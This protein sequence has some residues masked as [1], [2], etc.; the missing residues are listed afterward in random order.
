MTTGSETVI[1]AATFV[2]LALLTSIVA[3][4]NAS[5]DSHMASAFQVD[6]CSGQASPSV[7]IQTE[8]DLNQAI[9]CFNSG[10]LGP[11]V[12]QLKLTRDVYVRTERGGTDSLAIPIDQPNLGYA[13][14]IN[15][16]RKFIDAP[17]LPGPTALSLFTMTE[18]NLA[19]VIFHNAMF[20]LPSADANLES[21][22][23]NQSQAPL[24]VT[25]TTFFDELAVLDQ[26]VKIENGGLLTVSDS[27][28]MLGDLGI[29]ST[30]SPVLINSSSFVRTA[31]SGSFGYALLVE[32][33]GTLE[34]LN[35][36]FDMADIGAIGVTGSIRNSTISGTGL[37]GNP[38]MTIS[39]SIINTCEAAV[40]DGGNNVGG[41]F[42][43]EIE[44]GRSSDNG[45]PGTDAVRCPWTI[46]IDA[47]SPARSAGDCRGIPTDQRGV[48]RTP[49]GISCD[50][51]AF[52]F[53]PA[54]AGDADNS[55]AVDNADVQALLTTL[56]GGSPPPGIEAGDVTGDGRVRL[57][58]VLALAQTVAGQ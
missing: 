41:C 54:D 29:S 56:S 6:P 51:G 23:W 44:L 36:T 37:V 16:N 58:D 1:A 26:A 13:L 39:S 38:A 20:A 4:L 19:P 32:G 14:T 33:G 18:R 48:A 31:G 12:Y 34:I 30:K 53:F 2:L 10:T 43:V 45:C 46:P 21:F 55:G 8:A 47:Q 28:F 50:A 40:S 27:L 7:E 52:E 15:G 11:G 57:D 24:T 17:D 49:A 22:I 9:A 3:P 25:A 42:G 5:A 35:S